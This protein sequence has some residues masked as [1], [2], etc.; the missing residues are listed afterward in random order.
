MWLHGV[1][2]AIRQFYLKPE[3]WNFVW[4]D[5]EEYASPVKVVL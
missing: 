4:K 3:L 2:G 5:V 1:E